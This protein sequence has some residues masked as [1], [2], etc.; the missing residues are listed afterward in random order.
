[1]LGKVN[2]SGGTVTVNSIQ[3]QLFPILNF[4][5]SGVPFTLGTNTLNTIFTDPFGRI[6]NAL[7]SVVALPRAYQYDM[8]G[9]MTSDGRF[10]YE[11]DDENR[12]AAVRDAQTGSLIQQN[13]YDGLSRR[14]EKIEYANGTATTNRYI[15]KDWLVLAVT[16]GAGNILETYTHGAD[17]SGNLGGSAGG[18]GGILASTQSGGSAFYHYDFNGNVDSIT[19]PSHFLLAK[20][21]YSPFGEPLLHKGSFSPRFQF[22]TKEFDTLTGLNYYGYRFYSAGVGRWFNR[23][24]IGERGGMN[25]Y[26][27]LHSDPIHR[28]DVLGLTVHN[29]CNHAICIK[30]EDGPGPILV[31]PGESYDGPVDG[32]TDCD[33]NVTKIRDPYNNSNIDVGNGGVNIP[34]PNWPGSKKLK[35]PPDDGWD[36]LFECGKKNR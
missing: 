18:I 30:P 4:A 15:Y 3:A 33:G 17:L 26:G 8:N 1:V 14:R 19:S 36:P 23:D 31:Q 7:S 32:V 34:G 2:Y 6:T 16:D 9:N 24:L 22:S 10:T 11:W 13:R 5:A 35:C 21:I 20:Y 29:N 12:L 27:F 25:L 28:V